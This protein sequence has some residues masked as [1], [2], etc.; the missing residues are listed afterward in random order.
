[1]L[2]GSC[3]E[4]VQRE[5]P[6]DSHAAFV[7]ALLFGAGGAVLGLALYATFTI[8]TDMIFGY[9]S[10][11]VG[12]IVAKAMMMGSKGIG[13]RRYQIAAVILT[14]AAVSMAAIPIWMVHFA[15]DKNP[16]TQSRTLEKPASDRQPAEPSNLVKD[17]NSQAPSRTLQNPAS[18]Q[19]SGEPS[20]PAPA[21]PRIGLGKALLW[22]ALLGLAS[23]FLALASGIGGAIGLVVLM[24]GVQIAWKTARGKPAVVVYGPFE[25]SAPAQ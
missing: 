6:A 25:N 13:G 14:Y 11:A 3:A 15:K 17:K 5:R 19:Q 8:L 16:R 12:Y 9:I 4:R 24:V 10:L 22:I 18:D 1:M 23:P 7:R 20:E 21:K 2:C